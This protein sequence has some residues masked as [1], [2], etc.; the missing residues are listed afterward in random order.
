[1]EP[2]PRLPVWSDGP[3]TLIGDAAHP[4]LPYLA[5]GGALALEDALVLADCL[6][7]H[8]GADAAAFR[9]FE[10]RRRARAERAQRASARQGRIYHLPPPLSLGRDC[11]LRVLPG[12]RLMARFD[13]LY[14]WPH[15][16][17]R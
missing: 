3:V 7:A 2:L 17:R 14:G 11:L 8:A 4:M 15:A 5:Q 16:A 12:A 1:M 10:A 9:S 6:N 13:W